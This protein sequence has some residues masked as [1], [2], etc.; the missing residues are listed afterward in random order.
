MEPLLDLRGS[1]DLDGR[2]LHHTVIAQAD[3]LAA[4]AGLVMRKGDGIP[5]ALMRG[6][7]FAPAKGRDA[8]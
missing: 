2:E 3:A 4:A 1:S 5:A 8:S 6:Y 7:E